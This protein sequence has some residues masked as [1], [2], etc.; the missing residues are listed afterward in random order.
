MTRDVTANESADDASRQPSDQRQAVRQRYAAIAAA[1]DDQCCGTETATGGASSCCREPE[2]ESVGGG[3]PKTES[4]CCDDDANEP[5]SRALGYSPDDL[6][7]V[8]DGANLGLGCG[9]PTALAELEEGETL[10]DLGSGAGFDCFLAAQEV[11][12]DGSVIGVDMT[13]EMVER[14]R[15]NVEKNAVENVDFRLGEIEHLPVADE[16]VDVVIS[17]CVVNLSPAKRRV[18]EEAYRVLRPGGRLAVT[19]VVRTADVPPA[20]RRTDPESV[21]ACIAGAA[22]IDELREMVERTGFESVSVRPKED[23]E[24]FIREWSDDRPLE[25]YYVSAVIEGEK[26]REVAG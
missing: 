1:S 22:G 10:V 4:S 16:R 20:R 18:F 24:A 15:A 25:S 7:R 17:N 8:S 13:P 9:N 11:G 3:E 21:A 12:E 5:Y 19:D 26:P 14:A 2:T 6:E 23:S